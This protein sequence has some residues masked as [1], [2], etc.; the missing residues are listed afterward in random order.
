MLKKHRAIS[1]FLI[2]SLSFIF[3]LASGYSN[4]Y[5][6]VEADFFTRGAKFEA[7]D[8]NDLCVD[9]QINLDF[10]PNESFII[11]S[12]AISLHR[13]LILPSYQVVSIDS[14]FSVL[15]C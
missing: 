10:L 8:L 4:Y 2:V 12:P 3:P 6:L 9:K 13:L 15:R 14:F 11:A 7:T 1:T 5:D